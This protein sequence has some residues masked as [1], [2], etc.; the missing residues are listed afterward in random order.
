[1]HLKGQVKKLMP[2]GVADR[3][4][5]DSVK[6]TREGRCCPKF[7][8]KRE[9]TREKVNQKSPFGI[10]K[11]WDPEVKNGKPAKKSFN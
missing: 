2:I 11:G 9:E 7:G 3:G 4:R 8:R 6:Q 1:M 5:I 10:E